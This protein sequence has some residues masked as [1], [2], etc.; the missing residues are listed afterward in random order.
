MELTGLMPRGVNLKDFLDVQ[1][2]YLFNREYELNKQEHHTEKYYNLKL[3]VRRGQPFHIRIDFNRPYNPKE[4][5]FW[6][7]YV[8]DYLAEYTGLQAASWI[9]AIFT[10]PDDQASTSMAPGQGSL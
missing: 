1:E 3:I 4:H 8:I 7:E 9:F 2:V 5:Q 10:A 6:I